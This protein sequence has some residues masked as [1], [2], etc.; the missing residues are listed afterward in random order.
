MIAL[1]IAVVLIIVVGILGKFTSVLTDDQ[2]N[3]LMA[4]S[5]LYI[6]LFGVTR[7][8]LLENNASF[9]EN[10]IYYP[11][12]F[13]IIWYATGM[14]LSNYLVPADNFRGFFSTQ[15]SQMSQRNFQPR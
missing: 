8:K 10:K 15:N 1:I 7:N 6:M 9:F 13:Y 2:T 12:I 5:F 11:L 14:G 4:S 3:F